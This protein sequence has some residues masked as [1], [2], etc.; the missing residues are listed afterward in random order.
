M[1]ELIE[2][3]HFYSKMVLWQPG[4]TTNRTLQL[5]NKVSYSV[6]LPVLPSVSSIIHNSSSTYSYSKQSKASKA[7]IPDL[8]AIPAPKKVFT[9][10]FLPD[11]AADMPRLINMPTGPR[12]RRLRRPC[13]PEARLSYPFS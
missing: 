7:N 4:S 12:P 5:L 13:P 1:N 10:Q 6:I 2:R 3:S 9:S 11:C 8:L